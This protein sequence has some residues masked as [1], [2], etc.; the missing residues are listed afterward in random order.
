MCQPHQRRE[1]Q[2]LRVLHRCIRQVQLK[3]GGQ[4]S[5]GIDGRIAGVLVVAAGNTQAGE[6]AAVLQRQERSTALVSRPEE[7]FS[8]PPLPPSFLKAV[9]CLS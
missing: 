5:K 8:D 2:Q 7:I 3:Q 6:A 1:Q 4:T 9:R